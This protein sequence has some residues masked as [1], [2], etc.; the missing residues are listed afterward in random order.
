MIKVNRTA[1]PT[2]LVRNEATWTKAIRSA[3]TPQAKDTAI[4]KYRH[5]EIKSALVKM[6]SG[7]CAYCESKISHIDYGDI[8]H[9]KPKSKY[10]LE[11]VKWENLLLACKRCN[12]AEYKSDEFPSKQKGG[13]L[14]NPCT[15]EPDTHFRFEFDV[16]ARLA[17]VF[18][19]TTRGDTSEKIY[20]LNKP[21]LLKQRSVQIR[22]LIALARYYAADGTVKNLLDE[23][24][25]GESEYAA[26]ARMVLSTYVT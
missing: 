19:K 14:I 4:E 12:G 22:R 11:A 24:A 5:Q 15:D 23:A 17:V 26:F 2:V 7:K 3:K 6:F 13:W 20:G 1:K 8:E 9:F 18:G 21:D 10:P 16:Q 25:K